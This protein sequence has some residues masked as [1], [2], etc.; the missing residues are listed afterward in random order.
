MNRVVVTG[1]GLVTPLGF[2]VKSNWA[3]I[4]SGKSGIISV[5][6]IPDLSSHFRDLYAKVPAK[7]IGVVPPLGAVELNAVGDLRRVAKFSQYALVAAGEAL[8]DSQWLPKQEDEL[9][10]TGVSIGSCIGSFEDLYRSSV[11][12][13][14]GGYRKVLPLFVPRYLNNMAAGAVSIKHGFKGPLLSMLTA[15][16][17][18]TNS[19][20]EAYRLVKDGYCDVMVAGGTE[21]I[22]HPLSLAGFARA[23]SLTTDYNDQ[24]TQA[25]R[26]FD[27]NR[28]GFV[29]SEGAG[30][31]VV[32][33]LDHALKRQCR[34]IYGEIVGYGM[35]GDG[36]HITA[37]PATG[38]G[39]RRAMLA[40]L[41][42]A[43]LEDKKLEIDYV[44]AHAT[45][46]SLGDDAENQAIKAIFG[47]H[48]DEL[49][50][51]SN[52]GSIGHLLGAS[53]A[54]EAIFTLLAMQNSVVPPTLNCTRPGSVTGESADYV[55][56]YAA[57]KPVAKNIRHAI[58][59]SF[60]F[61]G[62]NASLCFKKYSPGP[63]QPGF[64]DVGLV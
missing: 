28:S 7:V 56:N 32:E 4:L 13:D 61:G 43:G 44:N 25:S 6:D 22:T 21:A 39:A 52:K 62:V 59:N 51:S 16:A 20:G 11:E 10:K 18:G 12:F 26:P 3:G 15:C 50:V 38:D 41:R 40:A 35:S 53:G 17:T 27:V 33:K 14:L 47:S 48:R 36:H 23:K 63:S 19:I 1:I 55:F 31:V 60:G 8:E 9:E 45:L 37:P 5:L 54:V 30:V 58:S 42:S 46:T 57:N 2:G 49:V 34:T 24:P 29:L 64:S